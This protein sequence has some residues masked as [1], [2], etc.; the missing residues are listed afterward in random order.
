MY[1][2]RILWLVFHMTAIYVNL[3]GTSEWLSDPVEIKLYIL[4]SLFRLKCYGPPSTLP[5][6]NEF[7]IAPVDDFNVIAIV[8][9]TLVS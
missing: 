9:A 7:F 2:G 3:N 5:R 8:F 4:R 1:I 6:L